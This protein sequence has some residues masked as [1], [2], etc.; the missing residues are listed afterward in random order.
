MTK[1]SKTAQQPAS[2]RG[3]QTCCPHKKSSITW[4]SRIERAYALRR[5]GWDRGCSTRRVWA[6]AALC[7]W[8]A[9]VDDPTLPLDSELFVASQPITGSLGDPWVG[10]D[11][12][13]GGSAIP[14]AGAAHRQAS[15]WPNSSREVQHAERRMADPRI[16]LA[17][18]LQGSSALS[19]GLLHRRPPDR[20]PGDSQ[21]ASPSGRPSNTAPARSTGRR[22]VPCCRRISIPWRRP[23]SRRRTAE[24]PAHI[25]A[26]HRDELSRTGPTFPAGSPV[27]S[28]SRRPL[29]SS[30]RRP[31]PTDTRQAGRSS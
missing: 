4:P 25:Q 16:T 10:I 13:R 28:P 1:P 27:A 9:H 30:G 20:T 22:A 8:Q 21:A 6:A 15:P 19:P 7:L 14:V 31:T 29:D 17:S 3:H 26:I 23:R 2:Y 18:A 11:P 12:A 24:R 5:A